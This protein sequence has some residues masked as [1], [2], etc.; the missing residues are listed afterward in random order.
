MAN[1]R[2]LAGL[3]VPARCAA[4]VKADAYGLG[5]GEVG[6]ALAAAGCTTFFVAHLDEAIALRAVLPQG[7]IAVLNGL[8][9]GCAADY[10]EHRLL[11][12]LNDLA[13]VAAWRQAGGGP[14]IL[15]VDTGMARLGLSAA[16]VERAAADPALLAGVPFAYAMSH[17][18]CADEPG[19]PLNPAQRDAFRE[20][21]ARLRIAAPASFANSSGIFL[22]RDYHF[23]LARPG[24][25]LYGGNPIPGRPNPMRPVVRLDG[26]ILQVRGVDPGT[27]VGYGAAHITGTPARL[28]TVAVGYADGFMRHLSGRA[29]G[30]V[31]DT[32]VPLVGRV[33]MDLAIFDV[34][35]APAAV[36]GGFVEL[37]GPHQDVDALAAAAGTIGYEV[38]TSLGHRYHRRYLP[39]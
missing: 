15:H 26:R 19:H 16:E 17:L 20:A 12:V 24:V 29:Q 32:P 13:S 14:A 31:G 34:S 5:A 35:A 2:K 36:P 21:L 25:A 8:M 33:S 39:A 27:P 38:L 18:A 22:G 37:L 30:Y 23:D 9:P 11:P 6:P 4:V 10:C 1:W 28:A 7:E 3:V